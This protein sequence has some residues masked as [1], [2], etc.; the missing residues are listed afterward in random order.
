MMFLCN[1][2]HGI[3]SLIFFFN[4]SYNFVVYWRFFVITFAVFLLVGTLQ[5]NEE[6]PL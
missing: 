3:I 6:V 5:F 4:H 1:S 2:F